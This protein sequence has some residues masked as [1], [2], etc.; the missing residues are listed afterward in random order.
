MAPPI[1]EKDP[2][3][4]NLLDIDLEDH[5]D[6]VIDNSSLLSTLDSVANQVKFGDTNSAVPAVFWVGFRHTRRRGPL[7]ILKI[8]LN[9]V[10]N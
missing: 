2:N 10:T 9:G 4:V 3:F 6:H 5:V 8:L 1:F 7:S